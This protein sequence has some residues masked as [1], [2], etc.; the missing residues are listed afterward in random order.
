M[1]NKNKS[2]EKKIKKGNTD[3]LGTLHYFKAKLPEI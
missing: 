2:I 1:K 3:L